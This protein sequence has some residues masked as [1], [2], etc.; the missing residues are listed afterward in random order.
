MNQVNAQ[1]K[2]F[3]EK[4]FLAVVKKFHPVIRLT[5]NR[6]ELSRLNITGARGGFD[7]Q[8]KTQQFQKEFDGLTYYHQSFHELKLPTWYGIDL[9]LGH[10][11]INGDRINPEET[12]GQLSYIGFT[13]PLV[14]NLVMDKRRAALQTAKNY[15]A[16]SD[17]ERRIEVNNLVKES[18]EAYWKWWE[19]YHIHQLMIRGLRNSEKRLEFVRTAYQLGDRA[20]I[21]TL[22]A[23]TQ[24]QSFQIKI[25]ETLAASTNAK[26]ELSIYLWT[27]NNG[28][29]S[30]SQ[31]IIPEEYTNEDDVLSDEIFNASVS[32]PEIQQYEY[33]LKALQIERRLKFQLLLP[34][35]NL[36]YNQL[37]REFDKMFNAGWFSNNYNYGLVIAMPLRLSEGRAEYSRAGIKIENARIEQSNKRVQL[38]VK[39][40][41]CFTEW[42]QN[43][44]Q[45]SLQDKMV[46]NT[47]TLLKAEETRFLNGESNLFLI[48]AR[49]LKLIET[50]QK[51]I[52]L[53]TKTR[54]NYIKLQWAAG[55]YGG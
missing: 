5:A 3:S 31:D 15:F 54:Q 18:L 14:Q 1:Q 26:M 42:Q 29:V 37:N 28:Q 43:L 7:P 35:V 13:V 4:E 36:K 55:L 21:D 33:K 48:N 41:Q 38:Q 34:Q 47:A 40:R 32:H 25:A 27:E 6:M 16:L 23:F 51:L 50:E 22:E 52:E 17:V 45:L 30:L 49:E 2:V 11:K 19:Q 9:H 12:K 8:W 20:A 53:R 10:E 46:Q 24:V 44:N 39:L